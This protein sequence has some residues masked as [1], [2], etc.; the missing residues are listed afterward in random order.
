MIIRR[1]DVGM[2][3]PTDDS[4]LTA[5]TRKPPSV[6]ALT[7]TPMPT[8]LDCDIAVMEQEGSTINGDDESEWRVEAELF[9]GG[10]SYVGTAVIQ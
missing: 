8:I 6:Q 3:K 1:N 5:V 7:V 9:H 10:T 2:I 4:R